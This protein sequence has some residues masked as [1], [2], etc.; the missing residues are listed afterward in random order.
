M[1]WQKNTGEKKEGPVQIDRQINRYIQRE[2]ETNRHTE[3]IM[4]PIKN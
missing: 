1:I 3:Y 4:W 2:R